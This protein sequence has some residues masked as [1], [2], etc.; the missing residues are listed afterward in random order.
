MQHVLVGDDIYKKHRTYNSLFLYSIDTQVHQVSPET[1]DLWYR[2]LTGQLRMV[3]VDKTLLHQMR[4]VTMGL[5]HIKNLPQQQVEHQEIKDLEAQSMN[6]NLAWAQLQEKGAQDRKSQEHKNQAQ[7]EALSPYSLKMTLLLAQAQ[8]QMETAPSDKIEVQVPAL[9]YQQ[10]EDDGI[11]KLSQICTAPFLNNRSIL[12]HPVVM[13][14]LDNLVA[15]WSVTHRHFLDG[16]T[17]KWPQIYKFRS[18]NNTDTQAPLDVLGT[19]LQ[20]SSQPLQPQHDHEDGCN[21]NGYQT[22][23]TQCAYNTYNQKLRA[24]PGTI[25]GPTNSASTWTLRAQFPPIQVA[26]PTQTHLDPN[27]G[28]T[29]PFL[30]FLPP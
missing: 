16:G 8:E 2:H 11:Y 3:N 22:H 15:H 14:I 26:D 1:Y 20:P 10:V 9:T 30:N 23:I 24:V 21:G 29:T 13:G 7:E 25:P 5:L 17:C 4:Q 27:S 19:L 6:S 18:L 12:S 28:R